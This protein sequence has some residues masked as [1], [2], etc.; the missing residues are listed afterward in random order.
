MIDA[1]VHVW[2]L[3]PER[4]AW[5]QTLAHVP[6]PTESAT[7]EDL[8]AEMT[9]AGVRQTVLVQPSVYGWNNAYL[10]DCLER[11]PGCFAGVCLVDPASPR[12][13]ADLR[14]WVLQRGCS[15]VRINLI[16]DQDPAWGLEA[17]PGRVL[18]AAAE[19]GIAVELQTHPTHVDTI[20]ELARRY[21]SIPL[22]VDYLG[23]DAFHAP[24]AIEAVRRISE[25]PSTAFK[26]LSLSQDSHEAY[27]FCDL[28]PLL[29]AAAES[30]GAE[31]LLLGTD[32]PHVRLRSSYAESIGWLSSLPFLP[33]AAQARIDDAA[34]AFFALEPAEETP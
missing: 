32:F 26:M 14:H 15:G 27:P 17:G 19:L 31:R 24:A 11:F 33:P 25:A 16:A 3:D 30:F 4:Y 10:C 34:R 28:V 1:H 18:D 12:N 2:T 13:G 7:A 8:L 22:I 6:I 20:V 21:P 5:Q 29:R 23:A 9:A